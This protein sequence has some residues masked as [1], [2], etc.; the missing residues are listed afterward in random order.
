MVLR[1][2]FGNSIAVDA[3]IFFD[4]LKEWLETD[5]FAAA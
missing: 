2:I 1:E 5:C 3:A 4:G